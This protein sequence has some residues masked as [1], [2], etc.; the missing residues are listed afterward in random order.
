MNRTYSVFCASY[1]YAQ[2][3]YEPALAAVKT[4]VIR[5]KYCIIELASDNRIK[6]SIVKFMKDKV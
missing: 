6:I 4:L 3:F 1:L 2:Q 5:P